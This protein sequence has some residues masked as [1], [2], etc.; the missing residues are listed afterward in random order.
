[1]QINSRIY[2]VIYAATPS[3]FSVYMFEN[4]AYLSGKYMYI[5]SIK[6]NIGIRL[7]SLKVNRA[8]FY[9]QRSI[10]SLKIFKFNPTLV[11]LAQLLIDSPLYDY[12]VEQLMQIVRHKSLC[13]FPTGVT[14]LNKATAKYYTLI[15]TTGDRSFHLLVSTKIVMY[16]CDS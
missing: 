13:K 12:I 8:A 16:E 7:N 14:Y 9:T 1:M 5:I 6:I 3:I 15:K 11:C 2:S 4:L 10:I